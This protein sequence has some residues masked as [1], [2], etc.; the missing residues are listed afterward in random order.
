MVLNA[1]NI[2]CYMLVG[3]QQVY[4]MDDGESKLLHWAVN[5]ISSHHIGME[6]LI[7]RASQ[8]SSLRDIDYDASTIKSND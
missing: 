2:K 8:L 6:P 4:T 1:T 5:N 3:T 7:K